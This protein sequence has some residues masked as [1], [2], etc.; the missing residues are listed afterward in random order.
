M[1]I[2]NINITLTYANIIGNKTANDISL[3]EINKKHMVIEND[4]CR[5]IPMLTFSI[6][7]NALQKKDSFNN[8]N[9]PR[10]IISF[11]NKY[12]IKLRLFEKSSNQFKDLGQFIIDIPKYKKQS[13]EDYE[14]FNH[15]RLCIFENVSLLKKSDKE[16]YCIKILIK[17]IIMGNDSKEWIIQAIYPIRFI[18]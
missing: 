8:L 1:S 9:D 12:I 10:N 11:S 13:F 3:L 15:T 7:V 17:P 4:N 18:E 14:V 16:S 5:V 6:F 2:Q